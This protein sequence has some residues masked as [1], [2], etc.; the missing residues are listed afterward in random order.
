MSPKKKRIPLVGFWTSFERQNEA[1]KNIK[2]TV[3][4]CFVFFI[5]IEENKG[6]NEAS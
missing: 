2:K 1:P 4:F 6:W 5:L 3:Q